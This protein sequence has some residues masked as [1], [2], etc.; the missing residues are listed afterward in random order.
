MGSRIIS[1]VTGFMFGVVLVFLCYGVYVYT[2]EL[3]DK[4]QLSFDI[5][6]QSYEMRLKEK[7]K[8][9]RQLQD[10]LD[11]LRT[12][13]YMKSNGSII[14]V[15]LLAMNIYRESRGESTLG[16]FAVTEVVINRVKSDEFPDTIMGVILDESQFSWLQNDEWW[17]IENPLEWYEAERIAISFLSGEFPEVTGGALYYH[18]PDLV[19]P[20][21]YD[22]AVNVITIDNHVFYSLK[23][24]G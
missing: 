4:N 2:I 10:Q 16:K 17:N 19:T 20:F 15:Y 12:F 24:K 18:N 11:A 9:L 14:D 6:S 7:D 3:F 5:M 23:D 1:C 13:Q 21:Y 8:H 22:D